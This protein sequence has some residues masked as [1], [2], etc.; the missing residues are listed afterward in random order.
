M[1]VYRGCLTVDERQ[2]RSILDSLPPGGALSGIARFF[3][4]FSDETRLKILSALSMKELCVADLCFLLSTEQSTVSHQ[5]RLLRDAGIVTSRKAGRLTLYAI[6]NP[7]VAD[8]MM[9]GARQLR[10]K[11]G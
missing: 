8:V 4:V 9:T 2:E 10:R 11:R 3:A 6:V 7:Y 1:A 5:L